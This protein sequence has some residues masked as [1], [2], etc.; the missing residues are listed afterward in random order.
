MTQ[1]GAPAYIFGI[2]NSEKRTIDYGI[3]VPKL[4]SFLAFGDFD[5]EV[6][7]L[8][9]VPREDWPR[10]SW[11][12]Q[13]YHLMLYL[14][15]AMTLVAVGGIYKWWRGTLFKSTWWLRL[16]VVS[17]IFPQLANQAGWMSAEM[18]RYPWIVYNLLRISDGLS[19]S[20]TGSQILGSLIM[21]TVVYFFLFI[22]FIYLLDHKIKVGPVDVDQEHPYH[23][24]EHYVEELRK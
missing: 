6:E 15:G 10:V 2:P 17:V 13:A 1:A 11:V 7:G 4:L 19:A 18:G 23:S 3:Y 5:A 14:W 9:Q 24:I 22:L 20:V 12:F 8:D 16:M 21:F